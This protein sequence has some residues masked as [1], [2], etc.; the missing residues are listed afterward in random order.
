MRLNGVSDTIT[1][2]VIETIEH[3]YTYI[4]SSVSIPDTEIKLNQTKIYT[5]YKY[6][7]GIVVAQTFTFSANGDSTAYILTTVDGNSCT[8]K[9]L[10]SGYNIILSAI[11]NSDESKITTKTI[12]LKTIF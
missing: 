9:C 10:K 7:N 5:A 4:L 1:I 3:N 2:N 12:S 6:D 8:L 11:D